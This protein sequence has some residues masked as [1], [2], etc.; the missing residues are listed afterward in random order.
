MD[1]ETELRIV[2]IESAA[3][4][5]NETPNDLISAAEVIYMWITGVSPKTHIASIDKDGDIIITPS[6]N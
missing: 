3:T 6:D 2:C 1:E 4:L 5:D